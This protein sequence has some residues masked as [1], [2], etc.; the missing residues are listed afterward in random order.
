MF[1]IHGMAHITGG[2][3]PGNLKRIIPEGLQA[4]IKKENWDKLPVFEFLQK[5]GEVS[6]T[7]M[8]DAFNM[9]IG[10]TIVVNPG[11]ADKLVMEANTNGEKAFRIG[12]IVKGDQKVRLI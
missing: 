12:E 9:G 7:D 8:Y 1:D 10:Y 2:G 3:I 4:A 11:D 6:D 5:I